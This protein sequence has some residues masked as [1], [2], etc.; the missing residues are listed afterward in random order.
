[1]KKIKII[2]LA[3]ELRPSKMIK[4]EIGLFAVRNLKKETII[5]HANKMN[6]HFVPWSGYFKADKKTQNK[7]R[8]FCLQTKDGFYTPPDLNYLSVPWYMN[9]SC[10]Y[11]IGFDKKG[12]FIT[13]RNIK[14]GE[15]LVFD[16][17]FAISN[18]DFKMACKCK[19]KNCRGVI[20]GNDWLNDKFAKKNK[21]Y[22]L[23]ELF[24]N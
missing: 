18:P 2:Q 14:G 16:Y 5:A 13:T 8:Q 17:G 15:E 4:G 10:S 19:S 21:N 22:L 20:T 12:N 3:I 7:I 11:N 1:M 23:R 9:H 6:E 24:S